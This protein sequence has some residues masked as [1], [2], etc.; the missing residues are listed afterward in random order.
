MMRR[1]LNE[2]FSVPKMTEYTNNSGVHLIK[3]PENAQSFNHYLSFNYY[4]SLLKSG[5]TIAL[6]SL[7]PQ[8]TDQ[9][10]SNARRLID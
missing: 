2:T 1:K 5:S 9:L 3:S 7:K 6:L 8:E 4:L 10:Q